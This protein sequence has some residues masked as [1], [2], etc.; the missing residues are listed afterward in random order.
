MTFT[1]VSG[2]FNDRDDK[3]TGTFK[4]CHRGKQINKLKDKEDGQLVSI[5]RLSP[6]TEVKAVSDKWNQ[7]K[8]S[9]STIL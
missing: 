2:P 7:Q 3:I 4:W 5:C 8:L 6:S 1:A 9:V